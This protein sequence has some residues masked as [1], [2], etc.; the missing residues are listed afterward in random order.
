MKEKLTVTCKSQVVWLT[1]RFLPLSWACVRCVEEGVHTHR[2]VCLLLHTMPV[3]LVEGLGHGPE[4]NISS[5]TIK[6]TSE[7][8]Q[9]AWLFNIYWGC[10]LPD[11]YETVQ[12]HF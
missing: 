6:A 5:K 8:M 4:T 2:L 12:Y 11:M 7:M 1:G 10:D 3:L 9:M